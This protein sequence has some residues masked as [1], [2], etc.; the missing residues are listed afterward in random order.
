MRLSTSSFATTRRQN[1]N[2]RVT[3]Y[4]A[5]QR[6]ACKGRKYTR[7]ATK[8]GCGLL[9]GLCLLMP[10]TNTIQY[11]YPEVRDTGQEETG[12]TPRA[13]LL[14]R[15]CR[16]TSGHRTIR[17]ASKCEPGHNHQ[18]ATTASACSRSPLRKGQMLCPA[19][20]LKSLKQ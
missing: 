13:T 2:G 15:S 11:C 10:L 6:S 3:A 4:A 14:Q 16:S 20:Q 18:G 7:Q 9:R 8:K 1:A 19:E 5:S 17:S 12:T